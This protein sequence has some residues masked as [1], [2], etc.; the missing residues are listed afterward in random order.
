MSYL[1]IQKKIVIHIVAVSNI[2]VWVTKSTA[3]IPT[4]FTGS[5][6]INNFLVL[7]EV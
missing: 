2:N 3:E 4:N 1:I 5:N 6:F 7:M